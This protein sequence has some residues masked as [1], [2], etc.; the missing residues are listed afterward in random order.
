[1]PRICLNMIVKNESEIIERCLASVLPVIDHY[2]VCDTGSSDDTMDRI[3]RFFD[4]RGIPGEIHQTDFV[5][6]EQARNQALD[7]CRRSRAEFDYILLVDA[8]MEL[9]VESDAFRD[10]LTAPAYSLRQSSRV[11]YYN[12]RLLRRDASAGYVGVTHEYLKLDGRMERLQ[13]I[14]FI[15]HACGANRFEKVERD[16]RLLTEGL[17]REP[18]NARYMF[19]LAQTY[20]DAG[21]FAEAVFWCEKRIAAG[22]WDEEV[23]FARYM[24][25]LCFQALGNEAEFVA[26]CLE[27]YAQRPWRAEPLYALARHYRTAGKQEAAMLFCEAAAAIPYPDADLLFVDDQ[28]YRTGITE[29]MS[30]CGFYSRREDRRR[31]GY[32]SCMHLLTSR[33]ASDATRWL[34]LCN[35]I[36]YVKSAAELFPGFAA[37]EISVDMDPGYHPLNASIWIQDGTPYCIVRSVNYTVDGTR[38]TVSDPGQVIITRNLFVRMDGE[39]NVIDRREMPDR[40]NGVPKFDF[41]VDGFEDCRL[42]HSRGR[43]WCSC[44]VR[45]RNPAGR[46]EI[47]VLE[48]ADDAGL[49]I[50]QVDRVM[51]PERHQ[52]NW[53][54]L[55]RD[56]EVYFIYTV[57]PTIVLRFDL[58]GGGPT[59][60]SRKVPPLA[61]PYARGGSQ[62]VRVNDGWLCLIHDAFNPRADQRLYWHR[63]VLLDDD[64]AV[65]AATEPFY[66]LQK[67]I[68]FCAG[69]AYDDR[70]RRFVAS[71]GVNDARALLGFFNRDAVLDRLRS[72]PPAAS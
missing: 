55:M 68:E 58:E 49:S 9:V 3:R 71:F 32:E 38:Y 25:A 7:L 24:A 18:D 60:V 13:G 62:A 17:Q 54:P 67:G 29:E 8:D 5:D 1:M 4:S 19:Y 36:F 11:S 16:L 15:D 50:L 27:A 14:H 35:S 23:W 39:F 47:A 51:E 33:D 59:V 53:M 41:P 30:I 61:L 43:F 44:T 45:D 26:G 57:D 56:D 66:F 6:F 48:I 52:K 22:G 40:S 34:A 65:R 2:V 69:L 10:H 64:F 28:V 31:R 72:Q 46:C 63:F 70:G 42:F 37:K 20:R 12:P 21:R